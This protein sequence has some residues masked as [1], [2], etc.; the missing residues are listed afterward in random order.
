MGQKKVMTVLGPIAPEELGFTSMH[1]HIM[2]YGNV[3]GKRMRPNVP[4]NNLPIREADRVTLQ[5]VGL[6]LNNSIM[7]SDA[8]IQDDIDVMVDECIDFKNSGG[9]SLVEVSVPGLTL[10]NAA[11]REVSARSG[12]HVVAST[13]FYTWDSWPDEFR[14]RPLRWYKN[15][16]EQE[17]QDGI[18][19]TDI[20]P[21]SL[22]IALNDLN[23]MEEKA[24]R[25]AAQL[26]GETDLP[27]TI[28]PCEKA[29]G[30]RMRVLR[31]LREEGVD[32]SRVVLAHSKVEH[33]PGSFAEVI[34]NPKAYFVS[35]DEMK[36]LLDE[37]VNLCFELQ[38]PLGFE[39]MGE[40]HYGEFGKLAG[41]FELLKL[42]YAGQMVLG[43]DV[44]GQTMLRRSGAM[45]YLRLTTFMIP[46]L[47]EA[48]IPESAIHQMTTLNPARILAAQRST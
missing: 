35:A 6:L 1:E 19:G 44:C 34:R 42:G 22:K 31:I 29:G 32:L 16:M 7:A 24:L 11:L 5:N 15:R 2:F 45:G 21:G 28:H 14:D 23:Q 37:G 4:P 18:E 27:L 20:K 13:G 17:L 12:L 25:A 38:N 43:N 39:M 33:K 46:A 10:N 30:D 3:L 40:G 36:R 26:C 9:Q 41:L 47:L 48:G 8:L